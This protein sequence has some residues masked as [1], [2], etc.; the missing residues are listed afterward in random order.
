MP[1][2]VDSYSEANQDDITS[3]TTVHPSSNALYSTKGQSFTGN[4]QSIYS[5][6]FY[7][8]KQLGTPGNCIARL[9]A[10]TG[11]WGSTGTATGSPL[12]SSNVYNAGA[13]ATSLTL[14]EF[15][16]FSGYTLVNGTHYC[17]VLEAYDGT[18]DASNYIVVGSDISSPTH[19]GNMVWYADGAWGYESAYDLCFYVYGVTVG[20]TGKISGVTNPAEVMGVAVANIAKVKG[21]A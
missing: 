11:T 3:I 20:W 13:F 19:A 10:H 16:G 1:D 12:D 14:I 18:W 9:Y 5:A 6:K 15:T 2:I 7:V 17:I 21:V 4:G 8:K